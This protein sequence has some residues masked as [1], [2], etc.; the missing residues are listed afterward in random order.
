VASFEASRVAAPHQNANSIEIN[1]DKGS[2]RFDFE[3][4]NLLHFHDATRD[5]RENGW[6]R[7]MCTSADN[8][9]YAGNWWPDAHVLGYEHGFVNQLADILRVL[10]RKKP[11]VPLPDFADAYETQ[12]VL[13][14]AVLAAKNRCAVKLSEV[15]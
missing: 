12:R 13:E 15:R 10:G 14:A 3:D 1:G 11:E 5:D 2:L 8:H 4:M 7:I 6:T 9:P